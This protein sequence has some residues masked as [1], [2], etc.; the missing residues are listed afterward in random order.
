MQLSK[1]NLPPLPAPKQHHGLNSATFKQ[2]PIDGSLLIPEMFDWHAT[3]SPKHPLFVYPDDDGQVKTI[4]WAEAARAI[5]RAGHWLLS[6]VEEAAVPPVDSRPLF[7]IVA[8]SGMIL[9]SFA[10]NP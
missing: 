5:H 9:L 4:K 6:L 10:E 8:N 7:A 2:P 3:H 1:S